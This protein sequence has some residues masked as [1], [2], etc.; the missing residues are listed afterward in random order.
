MQRNLIFKFFF[1]TEYVLEPSSRLNRFHTLRELYDVED[2]VVSAVKCKVL[3]HK[4]T[5]VSILA[6]DVCFCYTLFQFVLVDLFAALKV[7]V[8]RITRILLHI[9]HA[10]ELLEQL[11]NPGFSLCEFAN[12]RTFILELLVTPPPISV[13]LAPVVE[14]AELYLILL[15]IRPRK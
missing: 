1:G 2:M 10:C 3:H 12:I 7:V 8:K 4:T 5:V 11:T 13:L 6:Q 9:R 14:K 15:Q